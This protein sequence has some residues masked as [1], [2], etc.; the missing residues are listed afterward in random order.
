[1]V[2]V[3][4]RDKDRAAQA[5][6]TDAWNET[7]YNCLIQLGHSSFESTPWVQGVQKIILGVGPTKKEPALLTHGLLPEASYKDVMCNFKTLT[8]N[9]TRPNQAAVM[10]NPNDVKDWNKEMEHTKFAYVRDTPFP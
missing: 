8:M 6:G 4:D 3:T 9:P 5:Q 1:M 7:L 2:T 10:T